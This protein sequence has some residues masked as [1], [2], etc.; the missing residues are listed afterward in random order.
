MFGAAA[1]LGFPRTRLG[2]LGRGVVRV[3]LVA[4]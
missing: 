2:I 1:A 3:L 4:T